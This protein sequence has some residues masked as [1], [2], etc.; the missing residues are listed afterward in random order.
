MESKIEKEK[1]WFVGNRGNCINVEWQREF[2]PRQGYK[3]I[4]YFLNGERI[5]CTW[6][7]TPESDYAVL[8]Y[9]GER[10]ISARNLWWLAS[11]AEW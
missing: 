2:I 5:Q 9:K 8:M 6:K 10:Y 4:G 1:V 11:K 3:H 7:E